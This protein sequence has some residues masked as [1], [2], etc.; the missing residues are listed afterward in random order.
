MSTID[1]NPAALDSEEV[2][3]APVRRVEH[4]DP[5]FTR[6]IEQQ[7]AKIPS[8]V[9]LFGAISSMALSLG[10][11]IAGRERESRFVGQWAPT[12]LLFGVYNKLVKTL[13]QR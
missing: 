7:A 9:F 2:Y 8:H 13:G 6:L 11:E 1:T 4:D 5:S 10:L 12:L 3:A